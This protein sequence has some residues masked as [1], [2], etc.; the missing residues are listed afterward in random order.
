MSRID[1]KFNELK[2]KGEHALIVFT[3]LGDPSPELSKKV[4]ES[5]IKGGADIIELGIPHSDPL[6]DGPLIQN[7]SK[8][9]LDAGM[10]TD[11]AFEITSEIGTEIPKVF[12][13]YYNLI[14]QYGVDR[15]TKKCGELGIDGIIVPDLPAEEAVL[16]LDACREH[17]VDLIFLVSPLTNEERLKKII[18]HSS[19]FLYVVSLLGVT[20]VRKS[21]ADVTDEVIKKTSRYVKQKIPLAVGFGISSDEHVREVIKSGA[22]GV[23]V[24]SALVAII[25]DYKDQPEVML[26]KIEDFTRALKDATR[27]TN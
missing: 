10:N 23:I 17:A 20:G 25:Q 18:E 11:M 24:G 13:V 4:A 15:F 16:M 26:D 22:D 8:R 14:L 6:A 21:L 2:E 7:A 3:M 12:L 1:D 19:G 9:A 5:M 27:Y